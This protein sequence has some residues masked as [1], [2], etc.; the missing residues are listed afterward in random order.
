MIGKDVEKI[1]VSNVERCYANHGIM[2][3]YLSKRIDFMIWSVVNDIQSQVRNYI[4]KNI[5]NA[6]TI[7]LKG[8][9]FPVF[10]YFIIIFRNIYLL[11]C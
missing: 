4:Q 10:K 6:I 3:C 2:I 5:V 7:L 8:M 1:G 11:F 9:W